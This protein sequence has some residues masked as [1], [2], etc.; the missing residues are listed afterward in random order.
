MFS[1][2]NHL[3]YVNTCGLNCTYLDERSHRDQF[4]ILRRQCSS[5]LINLCRAQIARLARETL[6]QRRMNA[7]PENPFVQDWAYPR[8]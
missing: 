7:I 1:F 3:A 6:Q 2:A 8:H 4:I 5:V